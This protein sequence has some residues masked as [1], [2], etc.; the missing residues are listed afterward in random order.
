MNSEQPL[1]RRELEQLSPYQPGKPAEELA[2]EYNLDRPV[3]KLA[4]NENPFSPPESVRAAYQDVFDQLNRY[5]DGGSYQ[6][7]ES[8]SDYYS[9]P[10]AG[11]VVGGGSDEVLDCLAKATLSP[12]DEVLT[13]KPAFIRYRMVAGMMGA[14]P[15]EV[16]LTETYD[17]DLN[18]LAEQ[19]TD[20]TKWICI[21][22]PNNPTSRYIQKEDLRNFLRDLPPDVIVVLDEAYFELMN[23]EDYPDGTTWLKNEHDTPAHVVVLRTFSKAFGMA[24]LRVGY[25]LMEPECKREIDK[26]RPP[27]NVTR[28]AQAVAR[29]ALKQQDFLQATRAKI[30]TQRQRLVEELE[31]R[32]FE[33]VPPSANFMLVR[34]NH[35]SAAKLTE[36]LKKRGIIIRPMS[37]YGLP[38]FVRVTVG[39]SSEN[40]R[41][42]KALDQIL[43]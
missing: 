19:I 32:D 38:E 4:S 35:L 5:P 17:I 33:V 27:F 26:I 23:F 9:W 13:A 41:F 21:P 30:A 18:G 3:V 28:P 15:V 39:R 1:F 34:P 22:N 20:D 14:T 42:L 31:A 6:L 25:G 12:G 11:I 7:R 37:P 43:G 36:E 40:E 24:G 16:P 29:V 8:L 2:R 10:S